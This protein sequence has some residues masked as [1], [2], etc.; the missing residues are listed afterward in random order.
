MATPTTSGSYSSSGLTG[1]QPVDALFYGTRWT[2]PTITFS[3]LTSNSYFSTSSFGGYGPSNGSGEPW[4][5]FELLAASD[6]SQTRLAL[7][8]WSNVANIN[9]VEVADNF[10]V[11]GDIR[12]GYS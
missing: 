1:V 7:Q 5:G 9:F 8:T 2:S 4:N 3:F 11:C 6:I 12:F 10:S